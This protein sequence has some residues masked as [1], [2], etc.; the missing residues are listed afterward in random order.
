MVRDK[1][2]SVQLPAGSPAPRGR[3]TT[4]SAQASVTKGRG[5]VPPERSSRGSRRCGVRPAS[6][7]KATRSCTRPTSSTDSHGKPRSHRT[8]DA[9]SD[10]LV[11]PQTTVG[12]VGNIHL[13]MR[14]RT[15]IDNGSH[16]PWQRD[17]HRAASEIPGAIQ[18]AGDPALGQRLI[19][20]SFCKSSFCA[21]LPRP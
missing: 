11:R 20:C 7:A 10:G 12:P 2:R 19:K 6:W 17:L 14:S 15:T 16:C 13:P 18:Q 21:W 3:G 4:G 9:G 5:P 8:G 1:W